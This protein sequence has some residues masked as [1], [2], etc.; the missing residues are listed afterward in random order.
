MLGIAHAERMFTLSDLAAVASR[1][2]KS[3]GRLVVVYRPERLAEL[4]FE[5]TQKRLEPKRVRFVHPMPSRPAK[6]VLLEAVKDGGKQLS[7]AAL[8][9][10]Q[11]RRQLH[12]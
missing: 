10:S 9:H 8:V 5:L 11:P 2:L 1:I 12:A 3:S 4:I 6:M 7:T